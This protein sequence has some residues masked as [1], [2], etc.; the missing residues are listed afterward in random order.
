VTLT[1]YPFSGYFFKHWILY[2]PNYPL[3]A[4]Y[5]V[6]DSNNPIVVVM[7]SDRQVKAAFGCGS[8]IEQAL[9]VLAILGVFCGVA[10]WRRRR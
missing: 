2:D 7:N 1:A 3:D 4:N 9:P 8:G 6:T 5:A 10:S